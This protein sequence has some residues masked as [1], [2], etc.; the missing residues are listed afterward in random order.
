MTGLEPCRRSSSSQLSLRTLPTSLQLRLGT[1][2]SIA[3]PE[4]P[5]P[6]SSLSAHSIPP[7]KR[8]AHTLAGLLGNEA[9]VLGT[10]I[11]PHPHHHLHY[12]HHH[13]HNPSLSCLRRDDISYRVQIVD[14]SQVLD[15]TNHP[16]RK[17][18]V[19]PDESM[20]LRS[21]RNFW[22]EWTPLE[23]M[24]GHVVHRWVPCSRDPVSRSH[25]DKTIL[26]VQVDDKLVPIIETG[27]IELGAEV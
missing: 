6:S 25:I 7:C 22:R 24:E 17:E 5:G 15:V 19:W 12:I 10:D 16:K 4:P 8:H 11:H 21:G 2:S 20:R 18:L 13:H 3:N 9:L 27:V 1:N 14:V 23:G 26:L